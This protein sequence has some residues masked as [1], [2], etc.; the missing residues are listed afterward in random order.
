MGRWSASGRRLDLL[1]TAVGA[2]GFV[3][4]TLVVMWVGL[5]PGER[6]VFTFVHDLPDW[7]LALVWPVMQAGGLV[8][9]L[10][11]AL[12]AAL[13]RRWRLA[14]HLAIAGL[15][16][17][18]I[19]LAVKNVVGRGRPPAFIADVVVRAETATGFGYPSGHAAVAAALAGAASPFLSRPWSR[20]VW[21]AAGVV[22]F[23]RV[24]VGAH[25]PVDVI[26]GLVLGWTVA[27]AVRVVWPA[28][29]RRAEPGAVTG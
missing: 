26:G 17:Y 5:L 22:A 25:F 18:E 11:A 7:L 2:A 23:A 27:N 8:A 19:A 10:V 29:A 15:A 24:Y 21:V 14:G 28:P 16:A 4:L 20:L 13:V 12:V 6:A 3:V 1:R 9:V